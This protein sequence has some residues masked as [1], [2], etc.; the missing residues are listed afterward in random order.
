MNGYLKE[1]IALLKERQ[2]WTDINS[3]W[4]ETTLTKAQERLGQK[5]RS[6]EV[7]KWIAQQLKQQGVNP[8]GVVGSADLAKVKDLFKSDRA[9]DFS[10]YS[11]LDSELQKAIKQFFKDYQDRWDEGWLALTRS[12]STF[13]EQSLRD[14]IKEKIR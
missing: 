12:S 8:D 6:G 13:E 9:L 2:R 5:Q 3:F 10:G 1:E 14:G 7:Y 4:D 11:K